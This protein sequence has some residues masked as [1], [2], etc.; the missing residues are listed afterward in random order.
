MFTGRRISAEIGL[1]W[2]LV[3]RVV[4]RVAL[5]RATRELADEVCRSSPV[6]VRE[7]KGAI[8]RGL[9]VPMQQGLELEEL[10]WRRAVDS[11]DRVEGVAAFN[12]KRDPEWKNR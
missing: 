11:E 8:E 12:E 10:A 7:A 1:E 9:D 3:T 4:E 6:A 5:E 2:G